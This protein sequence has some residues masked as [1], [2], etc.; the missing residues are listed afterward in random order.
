L[1]GEKNL[2]FHAPDQV[3]FEAIL[4]QS[5]KKLGKSKYE[6]AY[7]NGDIFNLDETTLRLMK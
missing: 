7:K 6:S 4:K 1:S 2:Q 5:K 3:T